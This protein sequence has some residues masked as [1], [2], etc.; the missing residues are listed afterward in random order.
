MRQRFLAVII[1]VTLV[2]VACGTSGQESTTAP[3]TAV[4]SSSGGTSTTKKPTDTTVKSTGDKPKETKRNKNAK[5][6]AEALDIS[7]ND[8]QDYW[9]DTMP[10]I[11]DGQEYERITSDRLFAVTPKTTAPGCSSKGGKSTYDDV[12]NNAFYCSLGAFVAWDDEKL[13]PELY[14]E[15]GEY[16]IAM[17]FAH[18][19]GHAIQDQVGI[20]NKGTSIEIEN[21]A[22]CFAGAWTAHTLENDD[23]TGFRATVADLQS[24]VAGMLKF[25][26]TPG[27]DIR[28]DQAHGSGFDRVNGFSE[29]FEQGAARCA[30]F[31]NNPPPYTNIQFTSQEELESGGNLA[32]ED[33]VKVATT[34]L[35][36]YWQFLTDQFQPVDAVQTFSRDTSMPTCGDEQYTEDEALGTAFF[37]VD[38]NYVAWDE[39]MMRDVGAEIGDFGIAVLL[40]KQWAISAQVQDGQS[41]E[42]IES[43]QGTLQQSCFT[44]SWTRAVLDGD[45]HQPTES[46]EPA[47]TLSPGDLDEAVRSFLAFSETPDKKGE[48]ATGSAFE[49]IEAFRVG[50]LS[51]NGP[52]ECASYSES[53]K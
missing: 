4:E 20:I 7:I 11:Y 6:Y 17:V 48:T 39:E 23:E 5:P 13:L 41:K 31:P 38:D 12:K 30:D 25:R 16:A 53:G 45:K 33:A 43:K 32:Y 52:K 40:A 27:S 46:G 28:G 18:E 1:G 34:D 35:N 9:A 44:G 19:W 42:T 36:A 10:K 47:L 14:T 3:T 24:A 29:G 22:D 51:D 26:D 8:I 21:Q 2:A 15:F 50:F 37:C 49:Q